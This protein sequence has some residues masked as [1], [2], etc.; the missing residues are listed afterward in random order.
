MMAHMRV[1]VV[2]AGMSGLACARL[3]VDAGHEVTVVSAEQR[4]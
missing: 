1:V 4:A 2:G 3:L